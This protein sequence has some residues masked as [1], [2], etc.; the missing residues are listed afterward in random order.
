MFKRLFGPILSVALAMT[1]AVSEA[2]DLSWSG[3]YR[4]EG[5]SLFNSRLDSSKRAKSYFLHHLI[6]QPEIVAAD[7]LKIQGKLDI[8]ND[9]NHTNS[10]FGEALGQSPASCTGAQ[11]QCGG[12]SQTQG[13]SS[14]AVREMYL[15]WTN[16]HR[17]FIAGRAPSQFGLG[18]THNAGLGK[19]DHWY[20]TRDMVAVKMIAGNMWFMPMYGKVREGQLNEEDD[21]TDYVLHFQYDN[22]DSELSL[23]ILYETRISTKF[24]NTDVPTGSSGYGGAGATQQEGWGGKQL[25]LFV[26]K[27]YESGLKVGFEAG[28]QTGLT[29]VK[30]STG[31]DSTLDAYGIAAELDYG[32]WNLKTGVAS[33]DDPATREKFEGY[34]FDRNYDVALL[35]FNYYLGTSAFDAIGGS[36]WTGST[37]LRGD[38]EALSNA[39]YF[40]PAYKIS[41]G[42][43]WSFVTRFTWANLMQVRTTGA[44]KALGYELDLGLNY[45]PYPNVQWKL[46][47][48]ILSPGTAFAGGSLN[49]SKET[50]YGIF[51]QAAI[52]F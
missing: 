1:S 24:G 28:F 21:I 50:A 4:F 43:Q 11:G 26:K 49:L 2:G 13:S 12:L 40:S 38:T 18:M 16:D 44:D 7:N 9:S 29:G 8:F 45:I 3:T 47:L 22:P 51:S 42:D 35:L 52:S 25:N 31:A 17:S 14:I 32:A 6:L 41:M 27:N 20:D 30:T 48:G 46:D 37:E 33:G 36:A 15:Q 5:V 19:F 23:G 39:V 34:F 10:Q